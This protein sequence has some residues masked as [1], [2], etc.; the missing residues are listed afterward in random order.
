MTHIDIEELK[1]VE[2]IIYRCSRHGIIYKPLKNFYLSSDE[3]DENL[4]PH[5]DVYC[6]ACISEYYAKLS[7]EEVLGDVTYEATYKD[8]YTPKPKKKTGEISE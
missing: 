8:G 2:H 5:F 6:P 1:N 3:N 7:E 4:I